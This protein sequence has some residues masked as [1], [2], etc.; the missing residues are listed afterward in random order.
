MSA[1]SPADAATTTTAARRLGGQVVLRV[2]ARLG[3]AGMQAATLLLLARALGPASFGTLAVLASTG[4]LLCSVAGLG[5]ST[6]V[7][8][9][10]AEDGAD[11]LAPTLFWM[12]A[13]GLTLVLA[14]LLVTSLVLG[15]PAPAAV[16]ALMAA[17]DQQA[18]FTVSSLSGHGRQ[19]AASVA[20]TVQRG[21]PLI[22]VGAAD[23]AGLPVLGPV[24]VALV[25]VA[26][27]A[28]VWAP[29]RWGGWRALRAAARSS[30]GYWFS[31]LVVNLRQLEPLTVSTL[32]GAGAAGLYA[33]A[34]RVS[35]PLT[36][37]VTSMQAIAVPEMA[38]AR[39][40]DEFRRTFRLLFG[41]ALLYAGVLA[42]AS[43]LVASVFL[44][45]VGPQYEPARTLVTVMVL[46]AALSAI[47]QA[48]AARLLAVGRPAVS[49]WIIGVATVVGLVVLAVTA[50][51]DGGRDLWVAPL[52]TQSLILV[53]L[54]V[55][56]VRPRNT[57]A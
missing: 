52:V 18:E 47:S 10:S 19:L 24:G 13:I 36:I 44:W 49:A 12:Q 22:A 31:G 20:I 30:V 27:L 1:P 46:C 51:V 40:R 43:P 8:R 48:L 3:S 50:G 6:R 7:L 38:R 17:S 32:G 33:I 37:V 29:R 9:V 34:A 56:P 15:D 26:V 35:N 11:R 5:A 14:G 53:A 28:V 16:G 23:L 57:S 25:V 4:M 54:A 42:A 41:L 39:D 2:L 21:L 55:V 45:I